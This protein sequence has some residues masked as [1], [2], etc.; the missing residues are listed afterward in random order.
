MTYT[1]YGTHYQVAEIIDVCYMATFSV[2]TDGTVSIRGAAP[3]CGIY[4]EQK[5]RLHATVHVMLQIL[6]VCNV[7][8]MTTFI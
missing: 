8:L 1:Q 4:F 2:I 3:D 7:W 6:T 5:T